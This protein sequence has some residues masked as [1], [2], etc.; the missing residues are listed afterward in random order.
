MKRQ[1]HGTGT[2][3]YVES[4]PTKTSLELLDSSN[5]KW[6]PDSIVFIYKLVVH[7]PRGSPPSRHPL[8]RELLF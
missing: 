4:D 8:I 1:K 7:K 2:V 5:E 6:A 3:F